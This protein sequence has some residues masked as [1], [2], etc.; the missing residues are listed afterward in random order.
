MPKTS[1]MV[2]LRQLSRKLVRELGLLQPDKVQAQATPAHWH[3]LTE[4]SKQPGM[5]LSQLGQLLLLSLSSI[6]RLVKVLSKEG[7][8]ILQA[9]QDKRE[10][11]VS[12]TAKGEAEVKKID[13]F[14]HAK[15][16]GAFEFLNETQISLIIQA[17]DSYSG[18]LEKS[19]LMREQIKI[20]TLSTSRTIRKQ[21]VQMIAE[22]QKN[23]FSIPIDADTNLCVMKAEESFYYNKSYN[24]WYAVSHQGQIVGCVGLKRLSQQYGEIKK[25]FVVQAYR[26]KGVAQKLMQTL[27]KAAH[28]HRFSG[29]AIGT[30]EQLKAAQKFYRKCGFR[31]ISANELP[32]GFERC[33]L[34][35]AF[36]YG[37]LSTLVCPE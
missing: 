33:A 25:F 24:F 35:T 28:K 36:F 29:L 30:V 23:E 13:A 37:D 2:A 18:A 19:R 1:Q 11:S 16:L 10:K 8:V 17:I 3:A 14:S 32:E 9:G 27:L 34:D 21:I 7:Y 5:T 20:A 4:I 31:P 12:L 26:G 22:I 6:S 15:I